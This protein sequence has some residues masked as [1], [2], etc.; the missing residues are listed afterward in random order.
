MLLPLSLEINLPKEFG[1][2]HRGA[3][4][5][6]EQHNVM[7]V[8][9]SEE[10]GIISIARNGILKRYIDGEMLKEAVESAYGPYRRERGFLEK[11]S[12]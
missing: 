7:A 2:R 11:Q 4:G 10:T 8:V 12:G 9:V 1:T 3:I 6:T 5:I